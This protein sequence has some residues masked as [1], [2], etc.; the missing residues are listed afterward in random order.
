MFDKKKEKENKIKKTIG[1]YS[2]FK[3]ALN[4]RAKEKFYKNPSDYNS[5]KEYIETWNEVK[6]GL[7][8]LL[9]KVE[10]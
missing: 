4:R 6:N 1:Y 7:E 8:T 3:N 5:I 9:N 2:S 10:L